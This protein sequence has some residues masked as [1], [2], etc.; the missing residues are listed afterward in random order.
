MIDSSRSLKDYLPRRV[1]FVFHASENHGAIFLSRKI[2]EREFQSKACFASFALSPEWNLI[3]FIFSGA[4]NGFEPAVRRQVGK[5]IG[6]T[7]FENNHDVQVFTVARNC[8][9][10]SFNLTSLVAGCCCCRTRSVMYRFS[11]IFTT[12]FTCRTSSNW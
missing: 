2:F 8:F 5:R 7:S 4:S 6:R 1:F 12:F 9:A 11:C 3:K 10:A